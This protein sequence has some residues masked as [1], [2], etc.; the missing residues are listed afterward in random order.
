MTAVLTPLLFEQGIARSVVVSNWADDAGNLYDL[1]NYSARLQARP[2]SACHDAILE[3]STQ[4]GSII[5]S[6]AGFTLE[7]TEAMTA[8]LCPL[9]AH[10]PI[11]TPGFADQYL[12][13]EY[14]LIVTSPLGVPFSLLRGDVMIILRTV[15]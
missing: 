9:Y 2:D 14:E 1:T 13:G 15:R 4:D 3:L 8:G 5:V 6:A 10:Q 11:S 7:F 12:A